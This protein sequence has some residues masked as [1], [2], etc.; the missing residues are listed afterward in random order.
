MHLLD[1]HRHYRP[2]R[3]DRI[4]RLRFTRTAAYLFC[5]TAAILPRA[6]GL[7]VCASALARCCLANRADVGLRLLFES[8]SKRLLRNDASPAGRARPHILA[9]NIQDGFSRIYGSVCKRDL[10]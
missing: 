6:A 4:R 8:K 10:T 9:H 5:W 1:P 3:V 7:P 2:L